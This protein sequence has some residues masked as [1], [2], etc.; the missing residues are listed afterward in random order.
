MKNRNGQPKAPP[1]NPID[2]MVP[3]DLVAEAGVVSS[4]FLIPSKFE[5]LLRIVQADD[6]YDQANSTIFKRMAAMRAN[7]TPLDVALI[8]DA[9]RTAGELEAVG[10]SAYLFKIVDTEV[11]GANL[12]YY[13]GIVAAKAAARRIIEDATN[14]LA[15]GY[16]DRTD[17]GDLGQMIEAAAA[18]V[19]GKLLGAVKPILIGDAADAVCSALENPVV[20][21]NM[22][23]A[24]WGLP[25]LDG[26]LGPIMPGEMTII[27]ARPSMGKT[28][29]AQHI[30][31]HSSNKQRPAL[32]V[33]LEMTDREVATRELCRGAN[34]D[35][36]RIRDGSTT[37]EEMHRLRE[38]Q[39]AMADQ[40]LWV[41]S[42]SQATLPEIRAVIASMIIKHGVRLV[43]VDFITEVAGHTSTRDRREELVGIARGLKTIAK[44]FSVP[45]LVMSQ[46]N[47]SAENTEPTLAML[48]ECG[49]IEEFADLIMFIHQPKAEDKSRK[50]LIVAKYRNGPSGQISVRFKASRTEFSDEEP[51]AND[52][53]DHHNYHQEFNQW[54]NQ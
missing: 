3:C 1:R 39:Q 46:L 18:K 17:I 31:R 33:S 37:H 2:R 4:V 36:L 35:G 51:E 24:A 40:P 16:D 49:A 10:G 28:A 53:A 32:L 48:R 8:L 34:V 15:A 23:R 22:N 50:L 45:M 41:W 27:A 29:L 6:F 20:Q 5:E 25:S 52:S 44:E 12:F 43:A 13:A 21:D 30:L 19:R 54:N 38:C 47:R 11:N 42:P 26:Y 9:L 14:I 7:G